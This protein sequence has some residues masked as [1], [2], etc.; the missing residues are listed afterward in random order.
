MP[1]VL[2]IDDNRM[3]LGVRKRLLELYTYSVLVVR[4]RDVLVQLRKRVLEA[5]LTPTVP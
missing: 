4:G 3:G 1:T 5:F 2:Y